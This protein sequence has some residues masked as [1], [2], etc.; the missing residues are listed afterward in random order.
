[1]HL[2]ICVSQAQVESIGAARNSIAKCLSPSEHSAL[3]PGVSTHT[4]T[5]RQQ[6]STYPEPCNAIAMPRRVWPSGPMPPMCVS[7]SAVHSPVLA[8]HL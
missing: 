5:P 4:R 8:M 6:S 3:L 2:S 1:M 7:S